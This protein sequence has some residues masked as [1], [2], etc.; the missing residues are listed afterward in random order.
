MGYESQAGR[1]DIK[2][3]S[4]GCTICC[5]KHILGPSMLNLDSINSGIGVPKDQD[6]DTCVVEWGW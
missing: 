2:C 3:H 5:F 6:G 1:R 4:K